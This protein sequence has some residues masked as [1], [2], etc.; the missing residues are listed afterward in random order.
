M[1]KWIIDSDHSVAGFAIRYLMTANIR[2]IFSR[3]TGTVNF[4]PPDLPAL[5][6]EAR[7][8]IATVSTGV[9][10]RDE[11]LLSADFFDAAKFPDMTFRSTRAEPLGENRFRLHGDAAIHGITRPLTLEGEYAGPVK[12]PEFIGG[13]TSIGFVC[14]GLVNRED[15]GITWGSTPMEGGLV[16]AKEIQITLDIEADMS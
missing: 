12:L 6:V 11:H 15:F 3:I 13:E 5:S 1:A 4:D 8:E 7:I 14:R 16:A 2:G 9:R 10:K